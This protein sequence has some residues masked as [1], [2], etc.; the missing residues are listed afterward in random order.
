V[1]VFV[2]SFFFSLSSLLPSLPVLHTS[3]KSIV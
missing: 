3:Q 2:I 1:Y